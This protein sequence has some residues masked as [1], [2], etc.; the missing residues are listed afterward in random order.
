[1]YEKAIKT[2]FKIERLALDVITVCAGCNTVIILAEERH[3]TVYDGIEVV[4]KVV[5]C[6]SDC[7]SRS[8]GPQTLEEARAVTHRYPRR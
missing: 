8:Y 2:E 5:Y 3:C 7:A 4:R 1:M 6:G